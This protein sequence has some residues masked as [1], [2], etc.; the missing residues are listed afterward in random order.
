MKLL[1]C[2]CYADV[3]LYS[4]MLTNIAFHEGNQLT[5]QDE[6]T[7][8]TLELFEMSFIINVHLMLKQ[9]VFKSVLVEFTADIT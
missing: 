6:T 3:C 7:R 9:N 5:K 1:F 2:V 4:F 8:V